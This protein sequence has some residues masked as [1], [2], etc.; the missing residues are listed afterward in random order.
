MGGWESKGTALRF[1][2][3]RE[4]DAAW[5][6]DSLYSGVTMVIC[7]AALYCALRLVF[8][9]SQSDWPRRSSSEQWRCVVLRAL[10]WC[11]TRCAAAGTY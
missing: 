11:G 7:P 4:G 3:M 8:P 6:I 2:R 5:F 9:P 1:D 10:Q